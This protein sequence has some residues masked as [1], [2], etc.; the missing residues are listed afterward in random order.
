MVEQELLEQ[1][2][3][4]EKLRQ[5]NEQH[6]AL[7][8]ERKK[9]YST[10]FGCQANERDTETI[11]GIL[12]TLGYTSVPNR[13]D[14]DVIIFNTC[15]IRENAELKVYGHLGELVHLKRK[16]PDLIIGI[17][18]CMMQKEEVREVIRKKYSYVDLIFGTHNIYKLPEMICE[19]KDSSKITIDVWE[20]GKSIIEG[21]PAKRT[22]DYKALVNITYGCNNFCTYCVVPY[23]RGREKS[24]EPKDIIAEITDLGK[25]GCKEVTLLGQNVNSYGKT[26]EEEFV[27]SDLLRSINDI[28]GIERI[29]FMTSHPKDLSDDLIHAIRDCEKVCKHVHLPIQSGSNDIL[30]TMNRKY[31]REDYLL[32]VNKLRKEIPSIAISTDII[33]GFPGETEQDFEDT[34][35]LIEE[36]RFDSAY[37]FIYSIREGTPAATMENQID[38]KVKHERF[39]RLL[40]TLNPIVL[41]NSLKLDGTIQRVLIEEVSKNDNTV[42]AGRN[43]SGK[44]VH[45]KGDNSLIGTLADIKIDSVNTWSLKGEIVEDEK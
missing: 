29:R 13:E 42:L 39:K 30:K 9:Y 17:C 8:G 12:E 3:Y 6:F 44:S 20:E 21:I 31:T 14:A 18:G 43:E 24:R 15:L 5:E 28:E 35:S 4:T 36:V 1:E 32:V 45:F 26:L 25:N 41:E 19:S 16:N 2:Y 7:T 40:D 38:D 23:T 11:S 37:T 10:T 22:Y 34:L 27:F 33:V